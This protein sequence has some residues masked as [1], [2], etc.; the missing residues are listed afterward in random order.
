[1]S[2]AGRLW[3]RAPLWRACVLVAACATLLAVLYPVWSRHAGGLA[4]SYAPVTQQEVL[5]HGLSDLVPLFGRQIP[6][7]A[8][9]WHA[10]QSQRVK[11][12][13]KPDIV[14][15]MLVRMGAAAPTGILVVQLVLAAQPG[16]STDANYQCENAEN[17]VTIRFPQRDHV[18]HECWTVRS[19][20]PDDWRNGGAA[21]IYQHGLARLHEGGIDP[22]G[23]FVA[24]NW[25]QA[26]DSGL[27]L[28][29]YFFPVRNDSTVPDA[30]DAWSK[31]AA[32]AHPAT[33]AY[34]DRLKSWTGA[35]TPLLESGASNTLTTDAVEAISAKFKQ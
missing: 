30:P 9:T 17:L 20:V 12:K 24:A 11:R 25:F 8:G 10:V 26:D 4:S 18:A 7:P 28:V 21:G 19:R 32:L 14:A 34:L 29:D 33:I 35:W 6:L 22:S 5:G 3:V 23:M 31:A 1:M 13:D 16:Q 15:A 27:M 2:A